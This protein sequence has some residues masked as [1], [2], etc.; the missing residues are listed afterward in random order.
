MNEAFDPAKMEE[1]TL[2][3]KLNTDEELIR[4]Q[5]AENIR[6]GLPQVRPYRP[7]EHTAILVAGGPSLDATEHELVEAYW[8]GGKI[9]T[10]NGAYDWCISRNIRPS[11]QVVLDAREFCTRFV[12]TPVENCQY[13]LASQ[14]HPQAF[15]ICRGRQVTIWHCV[16]TGDD[17]FEMLKKFYFGR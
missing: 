10:V 14:V 4:A 7:N 1:L 8:R 17:E 15:E 5:V 11:M 6:R 2:D 16:S 3:G 9:V 12:K 13:L